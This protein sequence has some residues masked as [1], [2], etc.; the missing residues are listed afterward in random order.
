MRTVL[1]C[2]LVKF[3]ERGHV[4]LAG[5]VKTRLLCNNGLEP[6]QIT[7][8]EIFLVSGGG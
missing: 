2:E 3:I 4:R 6:L 1:S 8:V 7:L 5:K